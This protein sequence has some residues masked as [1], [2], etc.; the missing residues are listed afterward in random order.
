MI[1]SVF[2]KNW[3]LGYSWST[4]LWYWCYYP[5]RLRDALSPVCRIFTEWLVT[6]A[7][8]QLSLLNK[9]TTQ[10]NLFKK[11]KKYRLNSILAGFSYPQNHPRW[12]DQGE[13]LNWSCDLRASERP[14]KKIRCI[15]VQLY[16]RTAVQLYCSTAVLLYNCTVLYYTVLMYCTVLLRCPSEVCFPSS[17]LLPWGSLWGWGEGLS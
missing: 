6:C 10:T 7:N 15:A 12:V 9:S 5:H 1:F 2:Q 3:V 16:C 14:R 11:K 4:L 8:Y 13:A 17:W